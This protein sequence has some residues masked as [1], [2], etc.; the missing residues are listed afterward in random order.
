MIHSNRP[1]PM[2]GGRHANRAEECVGASHKAK[3]CAF[4]LGGA[5]RPQGNHPRK[6]LS[7]DVAESQQILAFDISALKNSNRTIFVC[8][9]FRNQGRKKTT[10]F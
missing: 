3:I 2:G 4:K 1:S 7:A 6:A 5:F 9:G 10:C 8:V